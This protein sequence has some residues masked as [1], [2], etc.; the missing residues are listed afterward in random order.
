MVLEVG[1][2]SETYLNPVSYTVFLRQDE[3]WA[4]HY[5]KCGSGYAFSNYSK[6]YKYPKAENA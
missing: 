2:H 5:I 4:E 3:G 6:G 1:G